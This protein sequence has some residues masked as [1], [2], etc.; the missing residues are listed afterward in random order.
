MHL[1]GRYRSQGKPGAEVGR[2]E[3]MNPTSPPLPG[4]SN[5]QVW[6]G[7]RNRDS[8]DH[9]IL[10]PQVLAQSKNLRIPFLGN[11]GAL[12]PTFPFNSQLK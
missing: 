1:E 9:P 3:G 6:A 4:V 2:G 10:P 11:L 12:H 8:L 5:A 7:S